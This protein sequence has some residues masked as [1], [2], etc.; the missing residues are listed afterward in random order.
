MSVDLPAPFGPIRPRI[1]PRS[2]RDV[3]AIESD[4]TAE[5]ARQTDSLE[6][7]LGHRRTLW[8]HKKAD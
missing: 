5:T 6:H 7:E 3:H 8:R 4:E 2:H 1:S